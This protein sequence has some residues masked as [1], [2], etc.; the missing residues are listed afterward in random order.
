VL[1]TRWAD[2]LPDRRIVGIDL[3]DPK[4]EADWHASS[5]GNLEFRTGRAEQLPF[6]E[7]E[8]DLVCAIE[9]LEHVADPERSVAE[10][11]RV[12]RRYVLASVPREP[13]WRALNLA[14]GA[15]VRQLGNTP[16]HLNHWSR[17]S[18]ERL[19]ARH[20]EVAEVRSPLPWTMVLLRVG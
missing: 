9:T 3:P 5:R 10:L 7:N 4:L 19:L 16:G 17:S 2:R 13:L 20:G 12:A 14:R 6:D 1:T 8:F 11:V 18:F 15:Y